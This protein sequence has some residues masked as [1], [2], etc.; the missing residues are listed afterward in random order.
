ML[1]GKFFGSAPVGGGTAPLPPRTSSSAARS[2]RL[3]EDRAFLTRAYLAT[4]VFVSS[5]CLLDYRSQPESCVSAVTGARR[6]HAV[7]R[8]YLE[9]ADLHVPRRRRD[10]P[11]DRPSASFPAQGAIGAQDARA[12]AREADVARVT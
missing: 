10:P 2:S 12:D 4:P 8:L 3:Y 9:W 6:H 7:R 1:E 5:A 11:L